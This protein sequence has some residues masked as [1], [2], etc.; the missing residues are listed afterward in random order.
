MTQFN[1]DS[2]GSSIVTDFTEHIYDVLLVSS[3]ASEH[4]DEHFLMY[5]C[6]CEYKKR[7][8]KTE[9]MKFILKAI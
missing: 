2:D 7:R 8:I 1:S 5:H 3:E 6:A 4:K 9:N